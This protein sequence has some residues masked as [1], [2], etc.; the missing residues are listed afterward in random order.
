MY[1]C[2]MYV[3]VFSVRTGVHILSGTDAGKGLYVQYSIM[4]YVVT[5]SV[6][7]HHKSTGIVPTLVMLCKQDPRYGFK[8]PCLVVRSLYFIK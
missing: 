7:T 5:F 4:F 1:L 8:G 2:V 6:R 3:Y